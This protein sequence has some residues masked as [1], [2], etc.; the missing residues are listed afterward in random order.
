MRLLLSN[1]DKD[2]PW[3][4][5]ENESKIF[6]T[7]CGGGLGGIVSATEHKNPWS[8]S[9]VILSENCDDTWA[10]VTRAK[11]KNPTIVNR[12]QVQ[13]LI[14]EILFSFHFL[15]WWFKNYDFILFLNLKVA[16]ASVMNAL[17]QDGLLLASILFCMLKQGP[18]F[19]G[20]RQFVK[21]GDA[22]YTDRQNMR[23]EK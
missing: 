20:H 5:M 19:S 3:I 22:V 18:T 13:K 2:N 11:F 7:K 15:R 21:H 4:W 23:N 16:V 10:K 12:F 14:S 17:R 6:Q 1:G 8:L 9:T